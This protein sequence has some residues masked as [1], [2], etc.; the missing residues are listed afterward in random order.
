MP[1]AW[2]SRAGR[3]P[4]PASQ[5]P[6]LELGLA[7]LVLLRRLAEVPDVARRGPG[8][9][10]RACPRRLG[11]RAVST[12]CTTRAVTPSTTFVCAVTV[13]DHAVR[14]SPPSTSRYTQRL[15][16]A[17]GRYGLSMSRRE[18]GRVE[19]D[20]LAALR[21]RPGGVVPGSAPCC[22]RIPPSRTAE[23]PRASAASAA[24]RRAR[25]HGGWRT[26][27][28]ATLLIAP[29]SPD[30]ARRP[31]ERL[32]ERHLRRR[33]SSVGRRGAG[34]PA[35]RRQQEPDRPP[36][37]VSTISARPPCASAIARTIARPSPAPLARSATRSPRVKRSNARSARSA[38][39][40]AP[41]SLTSISTP[42]SA[43]ARASAMSPAPWRSALSTRLPSA[44][45]SRSGSASTC[46]SAGA[47]T[48]IVP[49]ALARRGRRSGRARPRAGRGRRS[50][51][52][53]T[54]RRPSAARAR[55]SRSSASCASRSHS[56]TAA[57]SASRTAGPSPPVR[58]APSSSVLITAI[59]ERSSWLASATKRRSRSNERRSRS[60][61]ALSVSP[62]RRISSRARRQ[63]EPL[64]L[65][66]QRDLRSARR[67]IVS[68]GA[69]PPSPARSRSATRAGRQRSRAT[70]NEAHERPER[71]VAIDERLAD[72][73]DPR[74]TVGH[75]R[76][77]R[78]RG[79][80]SS[81]PGRSAV[82]HDA[83]AR[84]PSQVRAV[85]RRARGRRRARPPRGRPGSAAARR[86]RRARRSA[87]S[88]SSRA[89]RR[90]RA[91]RAPP[92]CAR[93]ARRRSSRRR[94]RGAGRR[95]TRTRR[96]GR[97]S[98]RERRPWSCRTRIGRRLTRRR[99]AAG[100]SRTRG[101]SRAT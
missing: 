40:P 100:G 101:P 67:R 87:R 98:P 14:R 85:E 80:S 69:A 4:R 79:P 17:I 61:I 2:R 29:P 38:P 88:P 34:R 52:G 28:R 76:A 3:R 7:V 55:T 27:A 48:R 30:G 43:A 63:R 25:G 19:A 68:T 82:D 95:R 18:V 12:S 44:W 49:A 53:R 46:R 16:G 65:A 59:G 62:S 23:T 56:S 51:S 84:R 36:E 47:S 71:L 26:V 32:D 37:G 24:G 9:T 94:R 58:S 73:D 21:Q 75:A 5:E 77:G 86:C 57:T 45:R 83:P 89:R 42:P 99:P 72:H 31:Y 54:G 70:A 64:R 15:P 66:G 10:S 78:A 96:R 8:R 92:S 6:L 13:I 60:S 39:N 93:R 90:A 41:W 97:R 1:R 22:R 50:G 74:R 11:A 35:H 81:N 91:A 20:R 33:P